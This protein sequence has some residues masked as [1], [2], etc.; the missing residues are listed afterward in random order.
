MSASTLAVLLDPAWPALG[1]DSLGRNTRQALLDAGITPAEASA[2][3]KPELAKV[4]G[5][6]RARLEHLDAYLSRLADARAPGIAAAAR[7]A[8]K[9]TPGH[10]PDCG[11]KFAPN[12]RNI[13]T[14]LR[15]QLVA[16]RQPGPRPPWCQTCHDHHRTVLG[17]LV[18]A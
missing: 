12:P 18:D 1:N 17:Q 9:N 7:E 14:D 16:T 4:P 5:L 13:V 11:E 15:G 6:G 2:M 8:A 3:P 10:C